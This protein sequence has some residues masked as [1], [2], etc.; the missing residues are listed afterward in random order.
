M[1]GSIPRSSET[2]IDEDPGCSSNEVNNSS[3]HTVNKSTDKNDEASKSS[4]PTLDNNR[5]IHAKHMI[6]RYFHQLTIGCG[7][8]KC[9][10]KNCASNILFEKLTPDQ[11][12]GRA[13]QLF[14]KETKFC[15]N[16]VLDTFQNLNEPYSF[17]ND[18]EV[19][20]KR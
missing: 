8:Q 17:I 20:M 14:S 7:N 18:G 9:I 11:A 1:H 6:E 16:I 4:I 5:R 10:N 12:A 2:S 3:Y 13:I 19:N 15:D